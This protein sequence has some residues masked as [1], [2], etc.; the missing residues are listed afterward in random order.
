MT[1]LDY[2]VHANLTDHHAVLAKFKDFAA[3]CGWT[4]DVWEPSAQWAWDGS[5]YDW[6][7]G[8]E[9][10]LEITSAG[11]GA[12]VLNFRFRTFATGADPNHEFMDIGAQHGEAINSALSTHPVNQ[13]QWNT[14]YR[15]SMYPG[16]TPTTWLFGNSKF[17]FAAIK[18]ATDYCFFFT[19]G[20]VELFDE[21]DDEGN[22]AGWNVGSGA[23]EWYEKMDQVPFYQDSSYY[24]NGVRVPTSGNRLTIQ[25]SGNSPGGGG[26]IC[27]RLITMCNTVRPAQKPIVLILHSDNIWRYLGTI[28]IYAMDVRGMKIGEHVKYGT[29]EYI[30][31]PNCRGLDEYYKG[32]AVRIN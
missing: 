25:F 26:P 3:A 28:P 24:Y 27:S 14:Y 22:F 15:R 30:T 6:L 32:I 17:L 16:T 2:E 5:K 12:Q 4:I 10:F 13:N 29:E 18:M 19:V 21:A 11:Y 8:N 20:S 23:T 1:V 9:S 31:F 7:S